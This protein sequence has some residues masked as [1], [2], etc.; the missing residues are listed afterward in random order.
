MQKNEEILRA[1]NQILKRLEEVVNKIPSQNQS[2]NLNNNYNNVG[3]NNL[4][5]INENKNLKEEL[6]ATK[7]VY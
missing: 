6:E 3:G 2:S 5:L 1:Q 4:D 7:K